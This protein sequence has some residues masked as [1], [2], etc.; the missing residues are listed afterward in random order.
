EAEPGL[1]A[2]QP[3]RGGG[4]G[5]P[6]R[7]GPVLVPVRLLT[8]VPDQRADQAVRARA[9]APDL[10]QREVDLRVGGLEGDLPDRVRPAG[11]DLVVE[12]PARIRADQDHGGGACMTESG[13]PDR[14]AAAAA[15]ELE[16]APRWPL[17]VE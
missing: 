10:V 9:R 2:G 7:A 11:G 17:C 4:L 6:Q 8:R 15:D 1:P 13:A 12:P 3:G 14:L 5:A 16:P